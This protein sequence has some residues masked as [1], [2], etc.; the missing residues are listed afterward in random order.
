VS[1]DPFRS[2]PLQGKATAPYRRRRDYT[3]GRSQEGQPGK[4]SSGR[5]QPN[6][7]TKGMG[8]NM[9]AA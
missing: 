1:C 3:A 6:K 2:G 4:A 9:I 5:G 8:A 7:S